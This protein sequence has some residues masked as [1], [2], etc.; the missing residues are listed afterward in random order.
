MITQICK[1]DVRRD[2]D[3]ADRLAKDLRL[4][5]ELSVAPTVSGPATGPLSHTVGLRRDSKCTNV[6]SHGTSGTCA[7]TA[8]VT[9]SST[10]LALSVAV[11]ERRSC[12]VEP[13]P[14][15]R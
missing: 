4:S 5:C 12:I 7:V 11:L 9:S 8:V 13:L 1:L 14:V 10:P 2:D 3:E 6:Q 15:P